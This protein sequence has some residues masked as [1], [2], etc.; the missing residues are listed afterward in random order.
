MDLEVDSIEKNDTQ[1]LTSF[2]KG[3]KTIG[4]KWVYKTKY[5]EK[6]E[7]DNHKAILVANG[8]SQR[9]GI[10]FNEVFAPVVRWNTIRII[11]VMTTIQ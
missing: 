1:E 7:V 3:L 2:P 11:L 9:Y 8:Y 6:G 4:V 5:N 10:D